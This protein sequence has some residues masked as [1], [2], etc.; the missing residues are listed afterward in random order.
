LLIFAGRPTIDRRNP[1]GIVLHSDAQKVAA[2]VTL[3]A[4]PV[5]E[6][7]YCVGSFSKFRAYSAAVV[8][9]L[10]GIKMNLALVI[11]TIVVAFAV[12]GW[13]VMFLSLVKNTAGTDFRL[14]VTPSA[15][16]SQSAPTIGHMKHP[17]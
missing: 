1:V 16:R 4:Q 13:T 12:S 11:V 10:G 15:V 7:L 6:E 5:S 2:R 9:S 8:R 14:G 3:N 17:D